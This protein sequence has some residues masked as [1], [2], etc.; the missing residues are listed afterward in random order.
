MRE[1][2]CGLAEGSHMLE[3]VQIV[4]LMEERKKAIVPTQA[5]AS[6]FAFK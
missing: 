5:L 4:P 3:R 6:N 2:M 1:D